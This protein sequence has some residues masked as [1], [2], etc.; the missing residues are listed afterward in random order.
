MASPERPNL[1]Q[2]LERGLQDFRSQVEGEAGRKVAAVGRTKGVVP[3]AV[4]EILASL[5]E[6]LG[7]LQRGIGQAK[8]L[9][10]AVDPGIALAEVLAETLP[11]LAAS[12]S[13]GDLPEKIGVPS[14]PF[15]SAKKAAEAGGEIMGTALK[16]VQFLPSPED[17]AN[18]ERGLEGLLGAEG[19][20]VPTGAGSLNLLL[21][22]VGIQAAGQ[23]S[24]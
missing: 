20:T 8:Q 17:L 10:T 6:L 1:F 23:S 3:D 19:S 22:K 13:M 11:N 18:I 24:A 7:L 4:R 15:D 12:L 9:S 2:A 21:E 5:A 14:G 16:V